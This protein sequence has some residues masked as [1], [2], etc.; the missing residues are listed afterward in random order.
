MASSSRK[1]KSCKKI[2]ETYVVQKCRVLVVFF[3]S[4]HRAIAYDVLEGKM[5]ATLKIRFELQCSFICC[6][7]IV[8][9]TGF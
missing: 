5:Q 3:S 8:A 4:L 7:K 1:E 2:T 9:F 6:Q